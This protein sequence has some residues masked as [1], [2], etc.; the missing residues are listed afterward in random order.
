MVNQ[1]L[2]SHALPVADTA[3]PSLRGPGMVLLLMATV[4]TSHGG[5]SSSQA[6]VS[7]LVPSL[8]VGVAGLGTLCH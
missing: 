3:G 5:Y 4:F 1:Q 2:P 7:G 8:W 6:F